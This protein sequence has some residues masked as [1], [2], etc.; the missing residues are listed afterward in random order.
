MKQNCRGRSLVIALVG[1]VTCCFATAQTSL[2]T[3]VATDSFTY[4]DGPLVGNVG[5]PWAT[6]SG[7]T[8]Q[9]LV[10]SGK[11][12]LIQTTNSEDANIPLASALG[13]G[14]TYY[15]AFDLNVPTPSGAVVNVYFAHHKAGAS[16]FKARIWLLTGAPAGFYR[17]GLSDTSTA[18]TTL[19]VDVWSTDLAYGTTYRIVSSYNY[20]TGAAQ[21]WVNPVN[22]ASPKLTVGGVAS[23]A[24]DSY[25]VREASNSGTTQQIIDNLCVGTLFNDVITCAPPPS[26]GACCTG[27]NCTVVSQAACQGGG[28]VYL[29]D[30]ALCQAGTCT[31]GACCVPDGQGGETCQQAIQFTCENTLGGFFQGAGVSCTNP[32]PCGPTG[33]CCSADLQTCTNFLTQSECALADPT[34]TWYVGQSCTLACAPRGSCCELNGTCTLNVTQAECDATNGRNWTQGAGS[35]SNCTAVTQ[36]QVIISEYYEAAP[37]FRKAIE[38]YN[39]SASAVSLDG[40]RL[41][42]YANGSATPTASASL[43][44]V[45]VPGMGVRVFINSDDV[46]NDIPNFDESTA[47]VMPSVVNFNGDDAVAILFI[48]ENT[49]VDRFGV[50]TDGDTG[51]R[52][53]DPYADS[54]WERKCFVTSGTDNFDSCNFDDKKDCGAAHGATCPRGVNPPLACA[55]GVHNDEW[56]YEGRNDAAGNGFHSLGVHDCS[57]PL[58]TGAC[59]PAPARGVDCCPGDLNADSTVDLLDVPLFVSALLN[60]VLDTCADMNASGAD[61]GADVQLFVAAVLSGGNCGIDTCT[62]LTQAACIA[63]GGTYQGDN[64]SC[65]P[66]PCGGEP[67]GACCLPEGC[68]DNFTQTTCQA[69]SGFYFGDGSTCAQNTCLNDHTNVVINE[70]RTDMPGSDVDEYFELAGPAGTLLNGLTYVII[71]DDSAGNG[72]M[73]PGSRSGNIE[74][75]YNLDGQIIPADGRFLAAVGTFTLNGATPDLVIDPNTG[76]GG[77]F[78]NSDNVSHLLVTG[79]TGAPDDLIDDDRDG[80]LNAVLPWSILRDWVSLAEMLTP[81]TEFDEWVYDF[82]AQNPNGAIVGPDGTFV[83]SHAYRFNAGTNSDGAGAPWQIGPFDPATGDDTPGLVNII[84]GACCTGNGETCQVLSRADCTTAAGV[85]KGTGTDCTVNLCVGACC[86][87]T[88]CQ[89]LTSTGCTNIAGTYLGDGTNCSGSPC[90]AVCTDIATA[91]GIAIGNPVRVC[92]IIYNR[93]DLVGPNNSTIFLFDASGADGQSGITVF[94][95]D[96]EIS[97]ISG[98]VGDR[99]EIIGTMLTFSGLLEVGSGA[100]PL[101]FVTNYGFVGT[102]TPV[103]T[104]LADLQE[105]NPVA[106]ARESELI[107]LECVTFVDGNG[108]NVFDGGT[109]GTNYTITDGTNTGVVR[110]PTNS[111]DIQGQF[112]PVGPV[113]LTGIL[114]QFDSTDPRTGGYQIL[115]WD[116]FENIEQSPANCTVPTG[117]CCSFGICDPGVTQQDCSFAGGLYLGDGSDCSGGC[118]GSSGDC[119]II[120]EVVDGD[121][122]GGTPKWIEITNTGSSPYQF[123][124]GGVIVQVNAATDRTVDVDL[125][126]VIIAA[127]DSYVICGT[128]SSG[129][130]IFEDTYGFSADLYSGNITGNGNDRYILTDAADGSNLIDIYGTLDSDNTSLPSPWSYADAV[131]LRIPAASSGNSGTFNPAEWTITSLDAPDDASQKA[132]LQANTTPGTHTY[133][134]CTGG[135]CEAPQGTRTIVQCNAGGPACA[136]GQTYCNYSVN[137]SSPTQLPANCPKC[138]AID[139]QTVCVPCTGNCPFGGF[140]IFKWS[141]FDG[142]GG[143]CYFEGSVFVDGPCQTQGTCFNSA[144]FFNEVP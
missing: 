29:G 69:A 142:Q 27:G 50:P 9:I 130:A 65:T 125:T 78:E 43:N 72:S 14:G 6:H 112:I 32:I 4:P 30:G 75:A 89:I 91:R 102:P 62:E 108:S 1:A 18:P 63:A 24:V 80:T 64:T 83:P 35:C 2:A 143:D 51:P 119:L 59:C 37:G 46:A 98:G 12:T 48:D 20:D 95:S 111:L 104:T 67:T 23:I 76:G 136:G 28:G 94:G 44:G 113:N 5:S 26:T 107:R 123:P 70:I 121:R 81:A 122:S 58:P 129:Q 74:R 15:A 84:Q 117:G 42:L 144:G 115:I 38:I 105:G 101:Q 8:G 53:S 93:E 124:A 40:H 56:I 3:I 21:L 49:V 138:V 110:V 17:I 96:L 82:S 60:N 33:A 87:G 134:P 139:G 126:G 132:A 120:S 22:E 31:A 116:L 25:G 86:T 7:T 66:D 133:D 47:I 13:A 97:L 45:T 103:L 141:N 55:D 41:A 99:I 54:A 10:S 73:L 88:T 127:G 52:G 19:G 34:A 92:G 11:I 39:P 128:G 135:Q 57:G 131:A 137:A 16:T 100:T 71:G 90:G 85:Y 68:E 114:S 118:P 36:K 77:V 106:E 61:N 140:A 109:S 79:F